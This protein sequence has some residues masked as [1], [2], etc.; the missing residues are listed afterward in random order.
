MKYAEVIVP[1]SVVGTFTYSIPEHLNND[2]V[3]GK[4]ILVQFGK[5]KYYTAIIYNIHNNN[6]EYKTKDIFSVIDSKP[7]INSLHLKFWSWLAEYYM[8]NLGD[9]YTAAM[10]ISLRIESQSQIFLIKEIIDE[11]LSANEQKI[12]E[13]LKQ[14]KSLTI[15]QITKIIDVKN[16]ISI[17]NKLISKSIVD[18]YEHFKNNYKPKYIKFVKI[19]QLIESQLNLQHA[20]EKLSRAKKQTDILLAYSVLSKLKFVDDKFFFEE[21]EKKDLLKKADAKSQALKSLYEKNILV[22]Y[23]KQISRLGDYSDKKIS[24]NQL[25]EIQQIAIEQINNIFEQKNVCLLHGITSSGKTEV[26]I[27]L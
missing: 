12:V 10:P 9:V 13:Q 26:Y 6:P 2:C 25:T 22:E 14:Q 4:R 11:K 21:V 15:G 24:F 8:C 7:I 1:L 23:E 16:P 19:S 18:I 20:F 5:K 3:V 17:V 27:H